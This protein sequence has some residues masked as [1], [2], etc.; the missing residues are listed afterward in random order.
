MVSILCMIG[1]VM[2]FS[3]SYASAYY[4]YGNSYYF[5]QDQLIWLILGVIV[6]FEMCIRDRIKA[7]E[8]VE[9]T[10]RYYPYGNF[11]SSVIGFVGTDN[12][13]L[14]GVEAYYDEELQGL[15]GKITS[16]KNASGTAMPLEYEQYIDPENGKNLVLTIDEVVQHLSLIHI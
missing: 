13:G 12:Y 16:A 7:I 8:L 3:A 14:Q 6:M 2:V 4:K 11:A 9:D 5:V 10:K 15:P 1:I